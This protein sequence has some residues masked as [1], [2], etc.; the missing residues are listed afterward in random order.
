VFRHS[1]YEARFDLVWREK[2]EEREMGR[3]RR[4]KKIKAIDPFA[5]KQKAE[6]D[7][8]HDEPPQDFQDRGEKFMISD[9][10]DS[11]HT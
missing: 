2:K 11:P 10:D 1:S 9:S 5:K 3:V 7:T 8:V 6:L 4:Y